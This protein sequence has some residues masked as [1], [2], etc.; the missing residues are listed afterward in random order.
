MTLTDNLIKFSVAERTKLM[1]SG[2]WKELLNEINAGANVPKRISKR[3][4]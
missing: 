1:H 4:R 2:L 3:C